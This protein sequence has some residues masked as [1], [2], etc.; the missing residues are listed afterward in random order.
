LS[1]IFRKHFLD[2]ISGDNHRGWGRFGTHL[3]GGLGYKW[4]AI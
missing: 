3:K 2:A 1:P 4:G